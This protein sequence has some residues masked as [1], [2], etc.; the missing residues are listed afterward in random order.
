MIEKVEKLC[1]KYQRFLLFLIGNLFLYGIFICM[2]YAEDTYWAEVMGWKIT[3]IQY[4]SNGRWLMVLLLNFCELVHMP[5]RLAELLSWT[6]A[7]LSITVA[8]ALIYRMLCSANKE[9]DHKYQKA[10]LRIASFLLVSNI[11][12]LEDFIFAEYTGIMCLGIL[13]DVIGSL[14]VLRFLRGNE[15]KYY[16]LGVV[17]AVLGI[18]GHQ[19]NF[20]LLVIIAILGARDTFDSI[21]CFVR[22]NLAIGSTYL[23]AALI[24]VAETK[25]GGASRAA[26]SLD[27]KLTFMKTTE[28]LYDLLTSS[29]NLMPRYVYILFIGL[30]AIYMLYYVV[31]KKSWKT[32]VFVAY[33]CVI[34]ILGIYAPYIMTDVNAIDVVPRTTYIMGAIP[35][36]ILI[37]LLLN[38]EI[39]WKR[40]LFIPLYIAC[41]I[42]MQYRGILGVE[43]SHYQTNELDRYEAQLIDGYLYE[44]E[45]KTGVQVTKMALYW[46]E[47]VTGNAPEAVCYGAVNERAFCNIWAAPMAMRCLVGREIS[48]VEAPDE[49][50]EEYFAGKDWCQMDEEQMVILGDTLYLC[51]Y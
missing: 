31:M 50:Y 33:Y 12:L 48:Q 22:N 28:G 17:F 36:A 35:P 30:I 14:C 46:D 15:K 32:L 8:E 18:N 29:A 21:R 41:F 13:F 51:A 26:Q 19:G 5:F 9:T 20:A 4:W 43:I 37:L 27:L 40:N 39:D 6:M 7:I 38:V 47:N 11:F 23:I 45:E 16:I 3:T 34:L 44:Y 24:N 1:R 49:I 42:L 10:G 25:I 2:H